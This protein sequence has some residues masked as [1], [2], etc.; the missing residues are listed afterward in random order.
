MHTQVEHGKM[1]DTCQFFLAFYFGQELR[2]APNRPNRSNKENDCEFIHDNESVLSSDEEN[3][4]PRS[5]RRQ[6]R[7]PGPAGHGP[8]RQVAGPVNASGPAS[9]QVRLKQAFSEVCYDIDP[10]L[11]L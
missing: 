9:K 4:K 6:A 7:G 10:K 1:N 5:S 11:R 3:M 8:S 2:R